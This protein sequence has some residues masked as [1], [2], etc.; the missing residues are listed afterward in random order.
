[1]SDQISAEVL[2]VLERAVPILPSLDIE[3][4]KDFYITKLGFVLKSDYGDYIILERDGAS[5]HVCYFPNRHVAENTSLYLYVRQVDALYQT[6]QERGVVSQQL[7]LKPYGLKEFAV[8]DPSGNLLRIG[9][10]IKG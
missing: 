5:L 8:I 6:W 9:E 3:S 10:T 4:S 1:M 7:E 2:P